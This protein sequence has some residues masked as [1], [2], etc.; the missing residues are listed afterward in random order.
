MGG[1]RDDN[2]KKTK[3]GSIVGWTK[4]K[5]KGVNEG[6]EE[7]TEGEGEEVKWKRR[8]GKMEKEEKR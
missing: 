3:S 1:G 4:R 7:W 5:G 6:W 2:K 8:R